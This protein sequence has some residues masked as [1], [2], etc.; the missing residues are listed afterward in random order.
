MNQWRITI[1]LRNGIRVFDP[2]PFAAYILNQT[3]RLRLNVDLRQIVWMRFN[4]VPDNP[5]NKEVPV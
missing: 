5:D 2:S 1:F 4:G 3:R